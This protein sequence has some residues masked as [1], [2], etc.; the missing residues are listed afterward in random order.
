[1]IKNSFVLFTEIN[2]IVELLTN[3]QKG[4]LFQAILDYQMGKEPN[5]EDP[6]VKIAFTSIKQDLDRNNEKWNEA[7]AR[8]SEAGKKGM[9]NRWGTK[10]ITNNNNVIT[11]ITKDN[12]VIA[13]KDDVRAERID[14]QHIVD[15]YNKICVSL[16][17]VTKLSDARKRA[18]KARLKNYS[19]DD[20]KTVFEMAEGSDFLSGRNGSWNASFDWLMN[21]TNL[22][23]V[24]DGNYKNKQGK[25]DIDN[26]LRQ[27]IDSN[28][29]VDFGIQG[30]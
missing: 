29:V 21:E 11:P 4:L 17:R 2:D 9:A 20:L 3:E 19:I 8:R 16:P 28:Q 18:I 5:L 22:T 1:M 23:K 27:F 7:R 13:K 26:N 10:N 25:I 15:M 24:L 12:N 6:I 30:G 14:Y